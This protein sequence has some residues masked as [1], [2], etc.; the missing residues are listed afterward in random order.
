[1]I[2]PNARSGHG[3][4]I[5]QPAEGRTPLAST[6]HTTARNMKSGSISS[7]ENDD[8]DVRDDCKPPALPLA[9]KCDDPI[10][11]TYNAWQREI[12]APALPQENRPAFSHRHSLLFEDLNEN[13]TTT[14]TNGN[15]SGFGKNQI[16]SPLKMPYDDILKTDDAEEG[17]VDGKGLPTT[18]SLFPPSVTLPNLDVRQHRHA[19][20]TS[21]CAIKTNHIYHLFKQTTNNYA[22]GIAFDRSS[23]IKETH[24]FA[25]MTTATSL[26]PYRSNGTS[27]EAN[28]TY[29]SPRSMMEGQPTIITSPTPLAPKSLGDNQSPL[30]SGSPFQSEITWSATEKHIFSYRDQFQHHTRDSSSKMNN[31]QSVGHALLRCPFNGAIKAAR[32]N[33]TKTPA[34]SPAMES[35][36]TIHSPAT[37]TVE[38]SEEESGGR[39][40]KRKGAWGM[41]FEL[42]KKYKN[43]HNGSCDVPQKDPLGAWVNKVSR[44]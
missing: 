12:I 35:K 14:P 24:P 39:S 2:D 42:L 34:P 29:D 19:T 3:A 40:K 11:D 36:K 31:Y 5:G 10:I 4:S 41:K 20:A 15:S 33:Y 37:A 38:S 25:S 9:M 27:A 21:A 30:L 8:D 17:C 26:S 6:I 43:E 13:G 28:A 22:G 18:S 44:A 32:V 7:M 16:P 23:A 1:M